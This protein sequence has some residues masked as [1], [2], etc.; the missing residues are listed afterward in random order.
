MPHHALPSVRGAKLPLNGERE[1][2]LRCVAVEPETHSCPEDR[3]LI[4]QAVTQTYL[5]QAVVGL[6]LLLLLARVG[7]DQGCVAGE[8]LSG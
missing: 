7:D 2:E 3:T 4:S 8:C 6:P 5:H 1:L